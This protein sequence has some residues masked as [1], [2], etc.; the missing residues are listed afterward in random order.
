MVLSLRPAPTLQAC[1]NVLFH[2]KATPGVLGLAARPSTDENGNS[3]GGIC[4]DHLSYRTV[5]KLPLRTLAWLS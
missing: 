2:H 4:Y 5:R 1:L 3:F